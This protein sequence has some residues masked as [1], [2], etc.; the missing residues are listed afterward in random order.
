MAKACAVTPASQTSPGYLKPDLR[1]LPEI[2]VFAEAIRQ[3]EASQ[4]LSVQRKAAQGKALAAA[5][6][7]LGEAPAPEAD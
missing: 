1:H 5:G 6:A 7:A 4:P 2:W 3:Y